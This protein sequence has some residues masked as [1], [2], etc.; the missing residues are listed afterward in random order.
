MATTART[1]VG[2]DLAGGRYRVTAQLG[3]G[4]M[5]SVYRARDANL[6]A[7]VVV[8][9]PRASLLSDPEFVGRFAREVRALV[10]LAH[11]HIVKV[12]DVGECDGDPFADMQF[13]PGGS[14]E[15]RQQGPA[16][17]RRQLGPQGLAEW[18]EPVAEAL[19]YI[20]KQGYVHRDVKP[21]NILFDDH[22]N[23][24][25]GD[26]G[27]AKAIAAQTLAG[28]SAALTGTGMVLGPPCY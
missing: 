20:H 1:W 19:D 16:G 26:F 18:L 15:Q 25:L 28:H 23:A 9:V 7:D 24:Y 5:G 6:D 10:R 17:R 12:T 11:P 2:R 3:E 13:L 27:V 4:G 21:A 14:L 22:G 8:K